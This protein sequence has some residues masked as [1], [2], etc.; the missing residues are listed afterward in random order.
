VFLFRFDDIPEYEGFAEYT[1]L[2]IVAAV[3]FIYY[4]FRAIFLY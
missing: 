2:E 3:K 1:L 4:I